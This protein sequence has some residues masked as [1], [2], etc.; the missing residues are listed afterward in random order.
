MNEEGLDIS[1]NILIVFFIGE[2][3]INL[4]SASIMSSRKA[5]LIGTFGA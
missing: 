5:S 4:L 2:V 3:K 1:K